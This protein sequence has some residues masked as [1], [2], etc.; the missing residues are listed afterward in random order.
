MR[1]DTLQLQA[2]KFLR[3][4]LWLMRLVSSFFTNTRKIIVLYVTLG[5]VFSRILILQNR[6]S[7]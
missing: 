1:A 5:K 2:W 7:E 3:V 4:L 6:L